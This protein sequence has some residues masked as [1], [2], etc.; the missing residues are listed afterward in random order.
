MITRR[1]L[2]IGSTALATLVVLPAF[3][4]DAPAIDLFVPANPGGGWDQT[5]RLMEQVMVS[6]GIISG[7]TVTNVGGAGGTVGLPQFASQFDGQGNALMLGGMV[8]VGAIISN[9]SPVTL[10]DVTPIARLTGEFLALVVPAAS[11]F[12]SVGDFVAA[13]KAD[14]GAV[15]VAG[16]SAGGSDH[17]LLGLIGKAAGVEAPSMTYV[18][19]AGGGEALAA[20]LGN[21]VAAGISGYGEFAEQIKAGTLRLLAISADTRQ[22]GI[23]G[24]TL[25]EAG[26]DVE[27]FNWRGC[28]GPP[29][30]ADE[31]KARL[32]DLVER[33]ASSE[34]W[35]KECAARNWTRITLTGPEFETFL[36]QDIERITAILKDLGLA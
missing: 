13:L 6:E 15:A 5:A 11:P 16:G 19:F 21:Q 2:L 20:L 3:A 17:I 36:A 14:P 33:M 23:D 24:P 34:A 4:Q 1:Q 35:A 18:P 8:M 30:L 27:L 29:N 26:V 7:A 32:V 28:F 12:Q 31:D 9:K 25:K 22:E 10:S